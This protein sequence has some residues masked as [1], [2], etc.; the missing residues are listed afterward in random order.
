[1]IK[2]T[3]Q[4]TAEERERWER[5]GP[6][7]AS[8]ELSSYELRGQRRELQRCRSHPLLLPRARQWFLGASTRS[9]PSTRLLAHPCVPG[10]V[11]RAVAAGAA[12]IRHGKAAPAAAALTRGTQQHHLPSPLLHYR[13]WGPGGRVSLCWL[14]LGRE[15]KSS[16][17]QLPRKAE[18]KALCRGTDLSSFHE[19]PLRAISLSPG[20]SCL[21]PK[22]GRW[23]GAGWPVF[24]P[25]PKKTTPMC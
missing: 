14:S 24:R 1:M 12:Q 6:F 5:Q 18:G 2:R 10:A 19:S 17:P 16:G 3:W 13:G 4:A 25:V 11:G 21:L 22:Q 7:C 9:N 20:S 8:S 15:K 23:K